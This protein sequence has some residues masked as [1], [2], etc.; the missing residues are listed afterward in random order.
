MQVLFLLAL[1]FSTTTASLGGEKPCPPEGFDALQPFDIEAFFT[2]RWFA[3][4]QIPNDQQPVEGFFCTSANYIASKG[5]LFWGFKPKVDIYNFGRV[6]STT[7]DE[8]QDINLVAKVP[9][10]EK[11]PSK[12]IVSITFIP[13]FLIG[14][15]TGTNYWVVDGGTYADLDADT[16]S[17]INMEWALISAG[18]PNTEGENGRCYS[19]TGLWMFSRIAEP[20]QAQINMMEDRAIAMNLDVSQWRVVDHAGCVYLDDPKA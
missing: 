5:G 12:G 11:E 9:K 13:P 14:L 17:G 3:L 4:R 16:S 18:A 1:L 10:P 20:T 15:F 6:G 8:I 7:S 2:G 19:K